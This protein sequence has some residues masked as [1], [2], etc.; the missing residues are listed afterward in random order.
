M[1]EDRRVTGP[2]TERRP[3]RQGKLTAP[4]DV[5]AH[6]FRNEVRDRMTAKAIGLYGRGFFGAAMLPMSGLEHTG[7]K[8]KPAA[9]EGR[10]SLR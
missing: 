6:P 7:M 4:V 10:F 2:G 3:G 9:L 8:D 5:F 1:A